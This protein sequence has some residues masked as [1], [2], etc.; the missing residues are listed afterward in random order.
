ML[1]VIRFGGVMVRGGAVKGNPRYRLIVSGSRKY[2]RS[3]KSITKIVCER[4]ITTEF[5]PSQR[6]WKL[7]FPFLNY[8]VLRDTTRRSIARGVEIS[9][10]KK[11]GKKESNRG[12]KVFKY[13]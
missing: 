13:F 8:R 1:L 12:E 10:R 11:A 9:W 6:G 2:I 7:I 4:Y 5:A 3:L